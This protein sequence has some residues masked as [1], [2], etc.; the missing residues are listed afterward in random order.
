MTAHLNAA[1]RAADDAITLRPQEFS[2]RFQA[3]RLLQ[4]LTETVLGLRVPR[5]RLLR[6]SDRR[7]YHILSRQPQDPRQFVL[8]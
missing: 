2:A 4:A 6:N 7:V 5:A 1:G 8:F 3:N